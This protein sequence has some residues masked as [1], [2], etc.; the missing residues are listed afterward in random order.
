[1]MIFKMLAV[2]GGLAV[3]A[4]APA[5]V[6][7]ALVEVHSDTPYLGSGT[8]GRGRGQGFEMLAN[9]SVSTVGIEGNLRALN[10]TVDIFASTNGSDVGALLD[11][12]SA[13]LGGGGFGWYDMAVNFAFAANNYYVVNW[14]PTNLDADWVIP[15]GG[16]PGDPGLQYYQDSDLPVVDGPFRLV[17]GFEGAVPPLSSGNSL[18]PSMRYNTGPAAIPLPAGLSLLLVALGG[19]AGLRTMRKRAA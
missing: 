11:S 1:M 6:K 7:A 17:E 12:F 15:S 4:L 3:A 2:A 5:P 19:L 13:A 10:Y 9:T 18:H 8:E 16:G 14:R